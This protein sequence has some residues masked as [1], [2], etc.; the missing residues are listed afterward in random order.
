MSKRLLTAGMVAAAGMLVAGC[1]E[2]PPI[3]LV[4]DD[5][6]TSLTVHD[7][8]AT[9][10][11]N[12]QASI[13]AANVRRGLYAMVISTSKPDGVTLSA[14]DEQVRGDVRDS[15]I[16]AVLS[17]SKP[18]K[19][20]GMD[21]LQFTVAGRPPD[22]SVEVTYLCTTVESAKG[23][24]QVVTWTESDKF[25][26]RRPV[27]EKIASSFQ[28]SDGPAP[29]AAARSSAAP[30]GGTASGGSQPSGGD[31]SNP[32]GQAPSGGGAM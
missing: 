20:N 19:I 3:T 25:D 14:K 10:G 21:A 1:G 12:G 2:P 4:S 24:H 8:T 29:P 18:V 13:Q 32:A 16:Q 30:A 11:L 15:L 7:M 28:S 31:G 5:G 6:Q 23:F 9:D 27:L 26:G 22:A 17:A